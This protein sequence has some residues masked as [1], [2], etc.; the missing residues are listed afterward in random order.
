MKQLQSNPDWVAR[1]KERERFRQARA[2]H[3]RNLEEPVVQAL[4]KAGV[5]VD[6][7]W[8]L[9]NTSVPYPDAIPVLLEHVQRPYHDEVKGG[10]PAH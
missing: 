3:F 9:V 7:V 4:R 10:S 8:D 6:S 5:H 1:N 2:A